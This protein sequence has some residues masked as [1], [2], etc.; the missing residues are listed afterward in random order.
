[1]T[2]QK[3]LKD[4]VTKMTTDCDGAGQPPK[5][6]EP[7]GCLV[8]DGND[9]RAPSDS[10]RPIYQGIEGRFIQIEYDELDDRLESV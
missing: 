3:F 1:M 9:L 6:G 4:K 5:V 10:A 7:V 8:F 2:I